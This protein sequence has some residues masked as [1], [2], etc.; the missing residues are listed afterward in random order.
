M[1]NKS[2]PV[3]KNNQMHDDSRLD[4]DQSSNQGN[5]SL[6][7]D[8]TTQIPDFGPWMWVSHK[9]RKNKGSG[10]GSSSNTKLLEILFDEE[11]IKAT[12]ESL[13]KWKK[14]TFGDIHKRKH[15]LPRK[16]TGE[17]TEIGFPNLGLEDWIKLNLMEA[18][19]K[20]NK[21]ATVV[22]GVAGFGFLLSTSPKLTL[23]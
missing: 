21:D 5:Q 18:R 1:E 11:S 22:N 20:S 8:D 3:V 19:D 14:D 9:P 7:T 12:Q 4:N 13:K 23:A 16:M 17:A 6:C 10:L 2:E 15:R